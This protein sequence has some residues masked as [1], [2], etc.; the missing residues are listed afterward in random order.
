MEEREKLLSKWSQEDL[1]KARDELFR[2]AT[3]Q[4]ELHFKGQMEFVKWTTAMA[5]GTLVLGRDILTE[6]SSFFPLQL[7]VLFGATLLFLSIICA[8]MFMH[9][10]L[11]FCAQALRMSEII[12]DMPPVLPKSFWPQEPITEESAR[13]ILKAYQEFKEI[14]EDTKQILYLA[15]N[16][17]EVVFDR[18]LIEELNREV[19]YVVRD[20]PVINDAL[21]EDAKFCGI[22]KIARV[23]SNGSD[24]PGTILSLCSKEF[25]SLYETA[26][27][28]ISKGQGNFEGLAGEDNTPIF[29][30]FKVKCPV[31]GND[32]GCQIGDIILKYNRK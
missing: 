4:R 30:L 24:A 32:I 3:A 5:T 14:L 31:I 28:I 16:A 7:I 11:D 6:L 22:D 8:A 19:I 17:G 27:L 12:L 2:T 29:F 9:N 26:E 23:I 18:I 13:P 21:V 15:D 1:S 25:L 10:W 20:K